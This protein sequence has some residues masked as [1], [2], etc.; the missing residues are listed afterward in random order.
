M[1]KRMKRRKFQTMELSFRGE[2]DKRK[3]FD[4][5]PF[6]SYNDAMYLILYRRNV[7]KCPGCFTSL[8]VQQDVYGRKTGV[9]WIVLECKY[10][11]CLGL[12]W[13]KYELD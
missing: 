7:R 11:R 13:R 6:S 9:R 5:V 2:M 10:S 12:K 1:E 4:F 8:C 3:Y